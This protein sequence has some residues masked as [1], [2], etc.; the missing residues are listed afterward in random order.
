MQQMCSQVIE[1]LFF[2]YNMINIK[3]NV[4]DFHFKPGTEG[5]VDSDT[6]S[7]NSGIYE[8]VDNDGHELPVNDSDSA[9][10]VPAPRQ[11]STS[12]KKKKKEAKG[13][14]GEKEKKGLRTKIKEFYKGNKGLDTE[15]ALKAATLSG[16][17]AAPQSAGVL[18]KLKNLKKTK[19]SNSANN[20]E[21]M[22]ND[23]NPVCASSGTDTDAEVDPN[24]QRSSKSE[25][26]TNENLLAPPPL[27]PRH[28]ELL[29]ASSGTDISKLNNGKDKTNR[30][31]ANSDQLNNKQDSENYENSAKVSPALPP[32]NRISN[33]LDLNVVIP[34]SPGGR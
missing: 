6:D 26:G 24:L 11:Q 2:T 27:P 29:R 28:S 13:E 14:K 34:V 32:R 23:D 5:D 12:K 4:V 10:E 8:Y 20:L 15:A 22:N 1:L 16:T 19:S 3:S 25:E 30:L 31:S 21:A 33:N 18:S 17:T 9:P 7:S